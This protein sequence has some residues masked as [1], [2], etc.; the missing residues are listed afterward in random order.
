MYFVKW[1]E[2][3]ATTSS[4]EIDMIDMCLGVHVCEHDK[5]GEVDELDIET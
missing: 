5:V 2:R 3:D 4:N 1:S